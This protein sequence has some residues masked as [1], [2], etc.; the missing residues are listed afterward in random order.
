MKKSIFYVHPKTA[1]YCLWA[2]M[3]LIAA[4]NSLMPYPIF[5][6]LYG[7][8]FSVLLIALAA[9]QLAYGVSFRTRR[10]VVLSGVLLVLFGMAQLGHFWRSIGPPTLERSL[11]FSAYY[12]AGKLVSENPPQSLYYLTLY[13]DG[14]M[15][16]ILPPPLRDTWQQIAFHHGVN[17][18]VPFIYSPF[19]AVFMKPLTY[20]RYDSAYLFWKAITVIVALASILITLRLAGRRLSIKLTILSIV[21]LFSYHPFSDELVL[22]QIGSVVLFLWAAGVWLLSRTRTW[23]SAFCF[24][25][26]TMIKI[27]PVIV[28]PLLAFHR[29]WKWLVAYTCWMVCLLI[30][31][32][33]QAGWSAHAQF[34]HKLMPSI[35][36]GTPVCYNSSLVAYIQELFLGQ[37]PSWMGKPITIPPYACTVSKAVSLAVYGAIMLRFYR[38]R[39]N[40]D[41]VRHLILMVLLTLSISPITWWH[42]YT[43]ALLPFIYLWCTLEDSR[44]TA[45]LVALILVVGANLAGLGLL[46][47]SNHVVQLILASLVPSLTLV[48]L[49][50]GI[51]A[52]FHAPA[53]MAGYNS[54]A[55]H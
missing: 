34:L 21:G 36:C 6:G 45:V 26:A 35:S 19:F 3:A 51:P 1:W 41:V 16:I 37:V 40:H 47:S 20:L 8:I 48:L 33:W 31:S 43:V 22:G 30:F 2:T 25:V 27:T 39:G 55:R 11:D 7:L 52:Q 49:Y 14:R 24:A 50:F 12:V 42:H 17:F 53:E 54:P 18:S 46:S 15:K 44:G 13:P 23:S 10:E 9:M 28:I 29:K 5:S 38:Y 4:V 32:V